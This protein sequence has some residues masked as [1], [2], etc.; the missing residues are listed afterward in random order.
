VKVAA[1]LEPA[2]LFDPAGLHRLEAGRSDQPLD[3][4]ASTVVIGHVEQ[5]GRLR[6]PVAGGQEEV[7]RQA[8]ERH[9][10]PCP[11][12]QPS[13][14]DLPRGLPVRQDTNDIAVRVEGERVARNDHE[15]A[16]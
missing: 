13:G 4:L 1:D 10:Q 16:G 6:R 9:G 12:G 14:H 8:S 3:C 15:L 7:G 2:R 11:R 5:D